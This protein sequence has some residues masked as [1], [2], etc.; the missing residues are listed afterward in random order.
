MSRIGIFGGSFNPIHCGHVALARELCQ[1]GV[2]DELWLLVSP[3]NPL[4][5][6]N[7]DIA[8]FNVRME[9]ALLAL[10]D[11]KNI[12]VSDFEAHLPI[13]SYTYTTLHALSDAYPDD[14]FYL[15][16]GAD[17]WL[18]FENWYRGDDII[19]EF[20]IL[21]YARPGCDID[22]EELP[23]SV[24][25]VNTHLYDISS[26]LVRQRAANGLSLSNL[27]PPEVENYIK[28]HQLYQGSQTP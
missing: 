19:K 10:K 27:V 16:I 14:E 7:T 22:M 3:L 18:Q 17:N 23:P 21:M 20:H 13:P 2:V 6:G 25:L 11:D 9:M 5:Q 15:V 28:E 8:D 26:T 4:K 1:S 24:T 12:K